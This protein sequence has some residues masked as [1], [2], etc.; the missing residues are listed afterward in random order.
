MP[1]SHYYWLFLNYFSFFLRVQNSKV[2]LLFKTAIY[3]HVYANEVCSKV[4]LFNIFCRCN[5]LW[6]VRQKLLLI[7]VEELKFQCLCLVILQQAQDCKNCLQ[8]EE[9][10]I[11]NQ[12]SKWGKHAIILSLIIIISFRTYF[13]LVVIAWFYFWI[14]LTY[15]LLSVSSILFSYF[16][17]TLFSFF[18][19]P[20]YRVI[21]MLQQCWALSLVVWGLQNDYGKLE[22]KTIHSLDCHRLIC[23]LKMWDSSNLVPSLDTGL[24]RN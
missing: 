13:I 9:I 23:L 22:W 7:K 5:L 11:N 19:I 4:V 20:H 18:K 21:T 17:I 24:S 3:N 2:Q 16:L 15:I 10:Y 12:T 6:Y 8:K 14:K 1:F